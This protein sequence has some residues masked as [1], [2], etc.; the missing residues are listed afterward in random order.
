VKDVS[1]AVDEG[2]YIC[3]VGENGSGKSTL[4]HMVAGLVKPTSGSISLAGPGR[5]EMGYLPQQA[6]VQKDFPASVAE[7]VLTGR[8]NRT[9]LIPILRKR[10]AIAADAALER[11]GILS[12][13]QSAYRELS[14]GQRQRV[15]LARAICASKKLLVLD[16]PVTGLDPLAQADMYGIIRELNAE[17]MT[18]LMVSHDVAGA[19]LSAN[20]ILHMA[21]GALFFGDTEE[22]MRS[23]PGRRFLG[24]H[25]QYVST[26]APANTAATVAAAHEGHEGT[27]HSMGLGAGGFADD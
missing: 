18:V 25:P 15:L 14:G 26:G 8:L 5:S 2:D 4:I 17:G 10:D 1:F 9:R 23:A 22:Y 20:R 7:V 16:E 27:P 24:G 21:T 11:L 3:V 19:V 13:R 6:P 12:L